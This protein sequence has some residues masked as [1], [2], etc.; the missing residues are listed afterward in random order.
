MPSTAD[1]LF[2]FLSE[3]DHE[4]VLR[5]AKQEIGTTTY[6]NCPRVAS[7]E[8]EEP[9]E[10]ISSEQYVD[11]GEPV[12]SITY[13][14]CE[15]Q[16]DTPEKLLI[17]EYVDRRFAQL[18]DEPI[19]QEKLDDCF[20]SGWM[21][22]IQAAID[23]EKAWKLFDDDSDED[24]PATTR[25]L[26]KHTEDSIESFRNARKR[27]IVLG[28]VT[29][30]DRGALSKLEGREACLQ[31]I[32]QHWQYDGDMQA[33]LEAFQI[34][35][36]AKRHKGGRW[37]GF[38]FEVVNRTVAKYYDPV[39]DKVVQRETAK[40]TISGNVTESQIHSV[41]A[42][43][44]SSMQHPD[45]PPSPPGFIQAVVE[46]NLQT[47]RRKQPLFAMMGAIALQ[48]VLCCRRVRSEYGARPNLSIVCLADT[49]AGKQHA[50]EINAKVLTKAGCDSLLIGN[51]FT[52]DIAL[53]KSLVDTGSGLSQYDEFGRVLLGGTKGDSQEYK[54]VTSLMMLAT[55][56]NDAAFMPKRYADA[57]RNIILRH[58]CLCF[59]A[60]S[61][62]EAFYQACSSAALADGFLGRLLVVNGK[63]NVPLVVQPEMEMPE[64]IIDTAKYWYELHGNLPNIKQGTV[65]PTENRIALTEDCKK[66]LIDFCREADELCFRGKEYAL[67][68]RAVEKA[69]KLSLVYACS[70]NRFE[71]VID[72]TA[73]EWGIALVR[74]TT[75]RMV[76]EVSRWVSSSKFESDCNELLRVIW[77]QPE[78]AIGRERLSQV[79]RKLNVRDKRQALEALQEQGRIILEKVETKGRPKETYRAVPP[80]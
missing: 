10:V 63:E 8:D 26:L 38:S 56:E 72:S 18:T 22:A 27:A 61:T 1:K 45:F 34:E 49:Q 2:P 35:S 47:A 52:C 29:T 74:A 50:R 13:F 58:P 41:Y 17:C 24:L 59:H 44:S 57:T 69:S 36:E 30:R 46:Y 53:F 64:T 79:Y 73:M 21:E 4:T 51:G 62:K 55:S 60:T 78:H 40:T 39:L 75:S 25:G 77:E 3:Q 14:W 19:D 31:H 80:S 11:L 7:S 15:G 23:S 16:F 37:V 68:G 12:G 65:E 28:E 66:L 6:S 48:A 71:P 43:T 5:L 20:H 70:A 9:P 33:C 54:I 76:E 67:W 42:G 32:C